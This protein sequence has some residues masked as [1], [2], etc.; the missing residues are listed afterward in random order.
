MSGVPPPGA[1]P[2]PGDAA[3]D[4]A[5]GTAGTADGA[6]HRADVPASNGGEGVLPVL[7]PVHGEYEKIH[8]IGEGTY[9]ARRARQG[10]RDPPAYPRAAGKPA[11][12]D[13]QA[14]AWRDPRSS[15]R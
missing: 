14:K 6:R 2:P 10:V 4:T 7:D 1:A 3:A 12:A 5:A 15:R 13:S 9:G 11:G 8:R